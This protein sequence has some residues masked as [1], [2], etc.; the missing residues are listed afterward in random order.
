MW[1][2][3]KSTA[4]TRSESLR[5]LCHPLPCLRT[6]RWTRCI[7][8]WLIYQPT[9]P[10]RRTH[11]TRRDCRTVTRRE[12]G[13]Q[14]GMCRRWN[15]SRPWG[16]TWRGSGWYSFSAT[17]RS[18][19]GSR[20]S[21]ARKASASWDASCTGAWFTGRRR[22]TS[23]TRSARSTARR[24]PTRASR[25]CKGCCE[26]PEGRS[27]S[28]S[29]PPTGRRHR[30]ATF[31]FGPS[32]ITIPWKTTSSRVHKRASPSPPA[33]SSKS[34]PRTTTTIGKP[35]KWQL[36]DQPVSFLLLNCR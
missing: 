34:S 36:L 22:C 20:W 31:S 23:A 9:I 1:L 10:T 3:T 16:K 24:W 21:W 15:N 35:E 18:R 5:L 4:K 14:T 8:I 12:T 32:S 19:W 11:L 7:K 27:P 6:R 28:R 33:T 25:P 13:A 17:R 26:R 29:C 30:R 2:L